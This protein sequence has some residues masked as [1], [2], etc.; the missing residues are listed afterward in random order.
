MTYEAIPTTDNSH[1][2]FSRARNIVEQ[3]RKEYWWVDMFGVRGE[4]VRID[5]IWI[6]RA[7]TWLN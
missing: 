4:V 6:S 3:K 1:D 5:R 7:R 2:R